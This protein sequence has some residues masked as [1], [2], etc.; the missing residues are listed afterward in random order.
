MSVLGTVAN[1]NSSINFK[2]EG[3]SKYYINLN[4]KI[5]MTESNDYKLNLS[6]GLNLINY[7]DKNEVYEESI[8]NSEEILL[9]PNQ[10]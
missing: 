4:G 5:I 7:G 3:S 9:S 10:L 8:F 6:K 1:D 2:L